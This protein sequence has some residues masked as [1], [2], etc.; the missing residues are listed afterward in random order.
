MSEKIRVTLMIEAA[1]FPR[2]VKE[3]IAMDLERQWNGKVHVVDVKRDEW[4]QA[5]LWDKPEAA[6]QGWQEHYRRAKE[7]AQ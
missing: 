2:G 5:E 3:L 7:T 4:E 1:S 6:P